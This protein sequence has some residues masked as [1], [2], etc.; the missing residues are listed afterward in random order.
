M[1]T[2]TSATVGTVKM[3]FASRRKG[4]LVGNGLRCKTVRPGVYRF[5][6]GTLKV[7]SWKLNGHEQINIAMHGKFAMEMCLVAYCTETNFIRDL[8][9]LPQDYGFLNANRWRGMV[10]RH[11]KS[12]VEI[13]ILRL[14][15]AKTEKGAIRAFGAKPTLAH[16]DFSVAVIQYAPRSQ[17]P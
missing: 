3:F 12:F 2:P 14:P 11:G 4:R 8:F 10:S 7:G 5:Y 1:T 17:K 9:D 13:Q 16:A 15:K 6:P